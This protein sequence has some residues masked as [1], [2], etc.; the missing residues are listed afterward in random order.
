MRSLRDPFVTTCGLLLACRLGVVDDESEVVSPD[1]DIESPYVESVVVDEPGAVERIPATSQPQVQVDPSWV[2]L[3]RKIVSMCPNL[4]V[5]AE[6]AIG[7]EPSE[8]DDGQV[9]FD[10]PRWDEL[11]ECMNE[12]PLQDMTIELVPCRQDT[13][14][15]E[16]PVEVVAAVAGELLDAG[17]ARERV[18]FDPGEPPVNPPKLGAR[19]MIRL[20]DE[21]QTAMGPDR[22]CT[23]QDRSSPGS[24]EAGSEVTA[25]F[26][27]FDATRAGSGR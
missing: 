10:E 26:D 16:D 14:D 24:I 6:T 18:S 19:V 17:I 27:D 1:A 9:V 21:P 20:V 15:S 2:V 12:G 22:V 7:L 5:R 4:T 8:S 11:A 23:D 3:D 13:E 25:V